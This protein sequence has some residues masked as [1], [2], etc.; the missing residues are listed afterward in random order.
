MITFAR[1]RDAALLLGGLTLLGY[2][3]VIVPEPRWVIIGVA[4]AM[5]GLP[6][7]LIADRAFGRSNRNH[8]DPP[9]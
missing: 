7:S 3:T 2:E 5:L 6:A 9:P 1:I 4:V 8:Q